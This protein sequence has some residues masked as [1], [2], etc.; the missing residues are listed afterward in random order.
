MR[1]SIIKFDQQSDIAQWLGLNLHKNQIGYLSIPHYLCHL[2]PRIFFY[3]LS[4]MWISAAPWTVAHQAPLSMG[5]IG[6]ITGVGCHFFLQRI[7]PTQGLNSRL[8]ILL[9]W[10]V[11]SLPPAAPGKPSESFFGLH[12]LEQVQQTM[13]EHRT[14]GGNQACP[15][16]WKTNSSQNQGKWSQKVTMIINGG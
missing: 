4:H 5:L 8:L 6:K 15:S 2:P 3:V 9:H 1:T 16:S 13:L 14:L 11:D 12:Y 7:F 10:Q